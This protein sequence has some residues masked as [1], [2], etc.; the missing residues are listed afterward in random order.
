MKRLTLLKVTHLNVK[1]IFLLVD[2]ILKDMGTTMVRKR[3]IYHPSYDVAHR[4]AKRF[5]GVKKAIKMKNGTRIVGRM[6]MTE[7]AV[8]LHPLITPYVKPLP[9]EEQV[10][11]SIGKNFPL[12]IYDGDTVSVY[13][14]L[15]KEKVIL[16]KQ[17]T[18]NKKKKVKSKY[19]TVIRK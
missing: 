4:R 13:R 1:D 18:E 14:D 2:T 15:N 7:A 6:T 5:D 19:T 3:S 9:G 11:L 8:T 10:V 16:I 12:H 17:N